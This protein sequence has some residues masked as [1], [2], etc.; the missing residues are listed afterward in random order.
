MPPERRSFGARRVVLMVVAAVAAVSIGLVGFSVGRLS[1][2]NNPTPGNYF[3]M[4]RGYTAYSGVSLRG[5]Y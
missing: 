1:T 4:V 3:V 5:A 2:I